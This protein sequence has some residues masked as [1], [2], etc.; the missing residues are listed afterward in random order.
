M[1]GNFKRHLGRHYDWQQKGYYIPA[2]LH[3]YSYKGSTAKRS[4]LSCSIQCHRC[5]TA[6]S[7]SKNCSSSSNDRVTQSTR[8][9]GALNIKFPTLGAQP[10]SVLNSKLYCR[11]R[12]LNYVSAI[13]K[14]QM[15]HPLQSYNEH[16]SLPVRAYTFRDILK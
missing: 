15:V 3:K 1:A 2:T 16:R 11:P 13:H 6:A 10:G 4:E 9:F 12:I 7:F 8:G 5:H 14:S